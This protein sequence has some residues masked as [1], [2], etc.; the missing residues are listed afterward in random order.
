MDTENKKMAKAGFLIVVPLCLVVIGG[1]YILKYLTDIYFDENMFST[2]FY[3][4]AAVIC[5][6]I[7]RKYMPALADKNENNKH[8]HICKNK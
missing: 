2:F 3:L 7:F 1:I 5:S 4:L 8:R 6:W